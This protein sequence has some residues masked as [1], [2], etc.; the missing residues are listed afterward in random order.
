MNLIQPDRLPALR[1]YL[2]KIATFNLKKVFS[3]GVSLDVQTTL[4]GQSQAS[5]EWP[6]QTNTM[7]LQVCFR[8]SGCWYACFTLW[9]L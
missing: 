6:T 8:F 4:K 5:I 2:Q 1:S 9:V 3:N 7:T